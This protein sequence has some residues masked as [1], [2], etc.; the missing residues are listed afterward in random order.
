MRIILVDIIS[1]LCYNQVKKIKLE[2]SY[3]YDIIRK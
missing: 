2:R 1:F 3:I